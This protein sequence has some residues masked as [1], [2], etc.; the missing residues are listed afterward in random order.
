MSIKYLLSKLIKK[1]KLP[2]IK[3]STV[4]PTSKIEAGTLFVNS[5]MGKYSFCG[6]DCEIT[7]VDIGSFVSIANNVSIGGAMHPIDW[8][9]MSPV[10][11]AGKDSVK[12]KFSSYEK[13]IPSKV[14]I[15]HDVWIGRNALIKQGIEIGHGAVIGMGSVVTKDV[16]PY[17]IVGGVPAKVI[18]YRFN[19]ELISDLL[20]SEWWN[21]EE[22]FLKEASVYIKNPEKFLDFIKK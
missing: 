20:D 19:D 8:V 5:C 15:N 9:A 18:K 14:I 22:H 12:K 1:S 11:Y 7:N 17:A 4:H 13:T 6:Y 21:L 16:P 10:F 2:S 3:N